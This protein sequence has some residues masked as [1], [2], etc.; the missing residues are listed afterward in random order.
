MLLYILKRVVSAISV[1]VVTLVASFALFFLAPTDPAG[2][3]CGTRCNADRLAEIRSSLGLDEPPIEQIGGYM[4]GILVGR[5]YTTSGVVQHCDAPCLGYS[6]T[7]GQPVTKLLAQALPVTVSIVLGGA[8]VYLFFGVLFGTLS[9]QRRGGTLD[10]ALIG[11][12]IV[13]NSIPY[14]VV[15]VLVA[16]YVT[17]LPHSEYHPLLSNPLL[18]A[19]GLVAA[20]LTLGLTNAAAYTRY[21]RASMIESLGQD[22]VRTARSK[23]ISERRVVYRHGLRAAL[24]PVVTIFGIDLAGQL[25]GAIFTE[26]IFGLPGIGVLTLRAFN[27]YD[28]PVL[29]GCV[30]LGSVVLVVMNLVVDIVYTVLDPRVRLG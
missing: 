16:L 19:S 30:L 3:I 4:K 7:L 23:G 6:Y 17:V 22:F 8:V 2:T 5:D 28:L 9:A 29:M 21:S 14:F 11:S 18:W 12:S 27:Q 24:T 20:W 26:Q 25:T 10:R 15:A 1:V 13:I